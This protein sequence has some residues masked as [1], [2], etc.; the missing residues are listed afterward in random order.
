MSDVEQT[1]RTWALES[2]WSYHRFLQAS[3]K[4]RAKQKSL[5]IRPSRALLREAIRAELQRRQS[6][7]PRLLRES[8]GG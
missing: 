7:S 2:L 5:H 6:S 3:D 4:R 1:V 8:L